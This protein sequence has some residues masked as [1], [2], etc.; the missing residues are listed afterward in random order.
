MAAKGLDETQLTLTEHLGELRTRI[1]YSIAGILL[2]TLGAAVYSPAILDY[3]IA[4]L[5]EV[6]AEKNRVD[7]LLVHAESGSPLERA[8]RDDPKVRFR[9]RSDTL[10]AASERVLAQ[11]DGK[12]PIDLV[13]VSSGVLPVDG[14]LLTDLLDEGR[15][16][17]LPNVPDVAYLVPDPGDP[18]VVEL[19]L[20]GAQVILD[21]P[22]P[23]ALRRVV[24]RA[25]AAA[26]KSRGGDKLVVLSVLEPFFAYLKVAL[27]CGLFLACPI[28]LYQ[29]WAFIA[30][31]LYAHERRF[32]LPVVL[33]GSFLFVGGGFFAYYGMFP[34]MFDFL[35]NQF[36]PD[37]L[38]ASFTVDKYLGLL[39]RITVAF[40]VVFELP[41]AL[42]LLAAVGLVD[43]A[44]LRRFRKYAY[45]GAT[46][47][48]AV[49]TP[50]DPISQLMMAVPL[51]V[52]YEI[53]ILLAGL[54][55][56]RKPDGVAL[57]P[58]DDDD[59]A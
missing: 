25:A 50:A 15:P 46:L 17:G 30:P 9:E 4:P 7:T 21:P 43:S 27:V 45:V 48:G 16:S 41:L 42:A 58:Q 5:L 32:A 18:R 6:L 3:S 37:T 53:G 40:G 13:M 26:G 59:R 12:R 38:A 33:S 35:V 10:A 24:R 20:E 1:L 49:L 23:A 28:W 47:L 56:R 52:F 34:V 8:L 57:V 2:T 31:G 14:T 54:F 22:R 44:K 39:M 36:M 29:A 11:T 19:Q 55:G 51:I